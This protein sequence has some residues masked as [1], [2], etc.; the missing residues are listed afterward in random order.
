M[1]E[2]QRFGGRIRTAKLM[3]IFV[4]LL[5]LFGQSGIRDGDR[6]M[7]EC[8]SRKPR[9]KD[10]RRRRQRRCFCVRKFMCVSFSV[11]V[12]LCV[13]FRHI[14]E[15]NTHI[16]HNEQ[17]Q[18]LSLRI[19]SATSTTALGRLCCRCVESFCHCLCVEFDT[20]RITL[21]IHFG[22]DPELCVHLEPNVPLMS[23]VTHTSHFLTP[24]DA[25]RQTDSYIVMYGHRDALFSCAIKKFVIVEPQVFR[26]RFYCALPNA[27]A[28][29]YFE[30]TQVYASI[31]NTKLWALRR[32]RAAF[33]VA[34]AFDKSRGRLDRLGVC[35]R[36]FDG[37]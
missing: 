36:F 9:Q 26:R 25:A 34:A 2:R 4:Q 1:L 7:C 18:G 10:R 30:P 19:N 22:S 3:G 21:T 12:W 27:N 37:N 33:L 8:G 13:W 5:L 31:C 15:A 17:K 16:W 32:S 35:R 20:I 29:S 24:H 23:H 6:T 14:S 28:N 11:C